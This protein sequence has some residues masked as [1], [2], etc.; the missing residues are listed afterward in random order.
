MRLPVF[1]LSLTFV[2]L[3]T[4]CSGEPSVGGSREAE[5]SSPTAREG[6]SEHVVAPSGDGEG[7]GDGRDD[8]GNAR[9]RAAKRAHRPAGTTEVARIDWSDAS[10]R[11]RV[12][13]APL[14]AEARAV[15]AASTVPVLLP[16]DPALLRGAVLTR[17]DTWYAASLH[18]E[19]HH[20]TV[21]GRALAVHQ[22][23]LEESVPEAARRRPGETSLTRVDGIVT[24]TFDAFGA[25]YTVNVE[26]D[27][28]ATDARCTGDDYANAL[29]RDL[30]V[31]GGA[32]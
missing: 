18:P 11:P 19:G 5:L 4:A 12:D 2:A 3:V 27:A 21:L 26:C 6:D 29:V 16:R 15:V 31:A 9:E 30:G 17:G 20:V 28:P 13:T 22:P 32:P 25:A 7:D 14:S 1:L 24:V 8:E 10:T 23:T